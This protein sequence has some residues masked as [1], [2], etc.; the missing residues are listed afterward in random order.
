MLSD[1]QRALLYVVANQLNIY[2]GLIIFVLGITGGILNLLVFAKSRTIKENPCVIYIVMGSVA[3]I[4][5]LLNIIFI[6]IMSLA[7]HI[8]LSILSRF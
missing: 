7:L 2:V 3:S 5:E 6:Q 8:D 1:S 4:L